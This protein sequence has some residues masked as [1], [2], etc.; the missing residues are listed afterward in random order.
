MISSECAA[1]GPPIR[2]FSIF[3]S[4]EDLGEGNLSSRDRLPAPEVDVLVVPLLPVPERERP[5]P[6]VDR[7]PRQDGRQGLG[8]GA[9][10][11]QALPG[12][13]VEVGGLYPVVAVDAQV[14][15]SQA[16]Y[17]HQYYVHSRSPARKVLLGH[18]C[19][20]VGQAAAP[21]RAEHGSPGGPCTGHLEKGPAREGTLLH[22]S[23][24]GNS[25]QARASAFSRPP[26]F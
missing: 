1:L 5:Y 23:P 2:V 24:P 16:V 3:F 4:E 19:K 6:R 11:T 25:R 9:V 18:L 14:V 10:E 17:D 12:E 20:A 26:Y 8:V 13:G 21:G 22:P 7:T 15:S